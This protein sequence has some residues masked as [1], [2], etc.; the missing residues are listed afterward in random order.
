MTMDRQNGQNESG[1]VSRWLADAV[2]AVSYLVIVAILFMT[3]SGLGSRDTGIGAD[4]ASL[5]LAVTP[6]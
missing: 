3:W 6:K 2:F 5:T 1:V 4:R